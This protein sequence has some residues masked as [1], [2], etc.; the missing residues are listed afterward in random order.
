M[1]QAL[2]FDNVHVSQFGDLYAYG[3]TFMNHI[4]HTHVFIPSMG[5]SLI[6]ERSISNNSSNP[7]GILIIL[8]ENT[9]TSLQQLLKFTWYISQLAKHRVR[10]HASE[11]PSAPNSSRPARWIDLPVVAA[12]VMR[13]V[14]GNLRCQTEM[15]QTDNNFRKKPDAAPGHARP[16]TIRP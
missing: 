3:F 5:I 1:R 10:T 9:K 11:V 16:H 6:N 15:G 2:V 13:S 4:V 8:T 14:A 12:A 7:L